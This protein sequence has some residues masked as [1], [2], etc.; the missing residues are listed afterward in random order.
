MEEANK[1]LRL[2]NYSNLLYEVDLIVDKLKKRLTINEL[3]VICELA[4]KLFNVPFQNKESIAFEL[5]TLITYYY[6][7]YNIEFKCKKG[8]T[9]KRK[10]E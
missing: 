2:A 8:A 4:D 6:E 3:I 7:K 1:Q 10:P 9:R 5:T